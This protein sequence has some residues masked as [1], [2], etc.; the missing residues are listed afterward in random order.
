MSKNNQALIIKMDE[1]RHNFSL[2]TLMTENLMLVLQSLGK[3]KD[4]NSQINCINQ[5][6]TA[7]P[8]LSE[9]CFTLIGQR[10]AP[11]DAL[12]Y[13]TALFVHTRPL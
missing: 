11:L 10:C 4:K 8:I 3:K 2:E 13:N 1:N 6:L 5:L 7:I 9:I 12:F